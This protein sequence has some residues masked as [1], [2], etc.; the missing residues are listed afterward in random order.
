MDDP[1][2]HKNECFKIAEAFRTC[3]DGVIKRFYWDVYETTK[4]RGLTEDYKPGA[5]EPTYFNSTQRTFWFAGFRLLKPNIETNQIKSIDDAISFRLV[6]AS[7][8]E[9][10]EM[11]RCGVEDIF[12]KKPDEGATG[13]ETVANNNDDGPYA[14]GFNPP[15]VPSLMDCLLEKKSPT[16]TTEEKTAMEV[17]D[18]AT[19]IEDEVVV[20]KVVTPEKVKLLLTHN[21]DH[22]A[23]ERA[24]LLRENEELRKQVA[25]MDKLC[26][27]VCEQKEST[28]Q[29]LIL[30][31]RLKYEGASKAAAIHR[32]RADAAHKGTR[33]NI[34]KW[35]R[36][37]H[38]IHFMKQEAKRRAKQRV[39]EYMKYMM[40]QSSDSDS[41]E[42]EVSVLDFGNDDDVIKDAFANV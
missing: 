37:M 20:Q 4:K 14:P 3:Q 5:K 8:R 41:D 17:D 35:N 25:E 6:P 7:T 19:E 11:Y 15:R 10:L 24:R 27:K 40:D 9:K 32:A 21:K 42:D 33:P 36:Q 26:E 2:Q 16:K 29:E 28:C 38:M 13:Q 1:S 12:S 18:D 23:K 22:F 34:K 30:A 39:A 31:E